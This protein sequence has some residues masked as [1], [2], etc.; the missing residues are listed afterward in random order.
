MLTWNENSFFRNREN[1]IKIFAKS[2]SA[3]H[4]EIS[5]KKC[6]HRFLSKE[7]R[8]D[9]TILDTI[10]CC[11]SPNQEKIRGEATGRLRYQCVNL[12]ALGDR[13]CL[14]YGFFN[15]NGDGNEFFPQFTVN[16]SVATIRQYNTSWMFTRGS[17][18]LN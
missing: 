11:L 9:S 3:L 18:Q 10:L 4:P 1:T 8:H 14:H 7:E 2:N 6:S 5:I 17:R 16:S 15:K 12:N 13:L